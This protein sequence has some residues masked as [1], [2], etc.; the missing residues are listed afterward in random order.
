VHQVWGVYAEVRLAHD[1]LEFEVFT[2]HEQLCAFTASLWHAHLFAGCLFHC[3]LFMPK[4][5][6]D[7]LFQLSIEHFDVPVMGKEP[8]HLLTIPVIHFWV[9]LRCEDKHVVGA[10]TL[11]AC[12]IDVLVS[13]VDH[14]GAFV[15]SML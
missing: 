14:H 3:M 1:V 4:T 6:G 7:G 11:L 12:M 5:T 8:L 13:S 2:Q 9:V 10:C 15:V